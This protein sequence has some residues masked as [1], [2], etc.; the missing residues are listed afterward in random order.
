M[1]NI[2]SVT[3]EQWMAQ[4]PELFSRSAFAW[5][6]MGDHRLQIEF[7]LDEPSDELVANVKIIGRA[8]GGIVVCATDR[9]WRMI[10]GGTRE[11]GET[12][13][14]TAGRE[15]REESGGTIT[16]PIV[17]VGALRVDASNTQPYRPHLPYPISYWLYVAADVVLDERPTNPADGENVVD[18]STLPVS[19]A[20]EYLAQFDDGPGTSVLRLAAAM[21]H[22]GTG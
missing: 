3:D 20:I 9:G 11:P 5:G 13:A 7:T 22:A 21:G 15:L 2:Q 14:E 18:V 12:I 8:D 6:G 17:T 10:P 4:F 1:R 19:E 16:G